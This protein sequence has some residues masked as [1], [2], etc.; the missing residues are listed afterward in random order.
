[1]Q[2]AFR[3]HHGLQCGFCTPGMVMSAVDLAQRA[4]EHSTS[5]RCAT[6]WRATSAAA[7]AITTSS[8]PCRPAPRRCT[9]H[10]SRRRMR[11]PS[12]RERRSCPSDFSGIGASVKRREDFRFLTG[13]GT[14][15]DDINRPGQTHA[16]ILRSPA[17][18]REDQRASTRPRPRRRPASSRSSPART[19]RPTRS[20]A[21]PA[22]GRSTPRTA[23]PMVE[24][25]HPLLAEDKVRHVGDHVA[26]VVAETLA[27][28]KRRGRADRG[29]LRG[30][31]RRSS[32]CADALKPGAP[33]VHD[34][35]RRQ[36]LLR[37]ASR[38]QGAPS[39]P[40][41]PRPRTSPSSTWST[42]GWSPTPME[43]RAAIGEYDRATDDYTLY[44]TARTRT[45]SAC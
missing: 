6:G 1:M 23:T 22:A 40:P 45:S 44:T 38:R 41:S 3:E 37:L 26:V 21:C 7:P 4:T 2:A 9:A 13:K 27:Q 39:T 42:T 14:Y 10:A 8:R 35:A 43:P 34:E 28:A 15:T 25:P 24:P 20:A 16:Y 12:P 30:A 36:P 31:C 29:R 11:G 18:P 33:Q 19:S 17:R 32:P 5:K